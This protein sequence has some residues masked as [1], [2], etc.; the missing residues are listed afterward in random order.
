MALYRFVGRAAQLGET[1]F[2]AVGEQAE[3]TEQVY[4][5][6]IAGGAAFITEEEFKALEISDYDL[7]RLRQNPDL[8]QEPELARKLTG[9]RSKFLEGRAL[10]AAGL[11]L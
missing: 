3:L 11:P 1:I 9:A 10:V 6:A 7:N 2:S 8:E 4:R 5:E